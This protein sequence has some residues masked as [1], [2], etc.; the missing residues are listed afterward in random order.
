[1]S[2]LLR[3]PGGDAR[4]VAPTTTRKIAQRML[5]ASREVAD[6]LP[7]GFYNSTAL[8]I[9]LMLHVAEDDAIYPAWDTLEVPG[10]PSTMTVDR[11]LAAL[12]G[13]GLIDRH[14]GL[15]ALSQKGYGLV[16]ATI[17]RVYKAQRTLD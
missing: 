7:A 4:V 12:T 1:M 11:W 14:D 17:E 15:I 6:A 8:D 3:L 2:K 9:L 13:E 10:R 5:C 16:V